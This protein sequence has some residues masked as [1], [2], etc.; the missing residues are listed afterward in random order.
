L[1]TSFLGFKESKEKE[2]KLEVVGGE[3]DEN[4]K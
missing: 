3:G 4:M 1:L 2:K